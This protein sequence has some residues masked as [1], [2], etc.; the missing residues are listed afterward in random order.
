MEFS[1]E[2]DS[3]T[4]H[5][6]LKVMAEAPKKQ[7]S[8]R[9]YRNVKTAADPPAE[10]TPLKRQTRGKKN[11][12]SSRATT[13]E[14]DETLICQPASTR[15]LRTRKPQPKT[16]ETL[17]EPD[18][19]RTIVEETNEVLNISTEQLRTSDTEAGENPASSKG[20][21]PRFQPF[22]NR[23]RNQNFF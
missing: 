19:M 11:T 20:M 23:V 21:S 22:Y 16:E 17:E 18:I 8:R 9:N 5:P 6:E 1:D 2:S 3:E 10:K 7:T 12:S 13:S 4:F 15:R 14:D